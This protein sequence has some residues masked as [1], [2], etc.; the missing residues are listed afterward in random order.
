[1]RRLAE[2][3]LVPVIEIP[4]PELAEPLAEAPPTR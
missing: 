3:V 1:M 4:E 2:F